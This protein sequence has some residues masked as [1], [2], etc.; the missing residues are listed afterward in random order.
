MKA[1]LIAGGNPA[2]TFPDSETQTE[3]FRKLDFLAVFD[4]FMTPTAQLA[5]LV[6][7]AADF[8][9]NMELHDY[10]HGGRPHLGLIKPVTMTTKGWPAWKLIFE[11]AGRL[12]LREL[13]PWQDNRQALIYKFS[14]NGIELSDLENS[15]SA[16]VSYKNGES[17]DSDPYPPHGKTR[18]RS[19]AVEK[20]GNPGLPTLESLSLPFRTDEQFPFWLSTGD[21][22]PFFQHSQFR[23]CPTYKARMEEPLLGIHPEAARALQICNGDFAFLSTRYGKIRVKVDLSDDLR[24]D[25]LRMTHG[26]KEGNV[27]ELTGLEYFDPLSGFPWLRALPAR[28]EKSNA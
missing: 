27:N 17:S 6:L 2:L 12:G 15:P 3:A 28:L 9:E 5:H 23:R 1:V 7:P 13:F 20:A 4:L 11:L 8:L 21:R 25:C 16:T 14:E 10:G 26:W 24:K 22:V 18:Y 19:E